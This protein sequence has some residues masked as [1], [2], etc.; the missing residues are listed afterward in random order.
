MKI[1][2][3]AIDAPLAAAWEAFCGGVEGVEIY[4][5]SIFDVACDAVVSPANSFGFMDG[6]IDALYMARF[7]DDI[8]MAVRRAIY[9]RHHG[10][11][12]EAWS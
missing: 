7:G 11:L 8:Q 2:L 6:G 3:T 9:E 4:R 5:G 1:V 12:I 10:E